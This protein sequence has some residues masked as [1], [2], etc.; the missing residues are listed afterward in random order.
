MWWEI[1]PKN[2]YLLELIKRRPKVQEQNMPFERGLN[3]DQWK[4]FSENYKQWE[5]DYG[6][7]TNLLRIIV[8]CDFWPT[9]EELSY[10]SWQN[11]CFNLSSTCHIK[12][13]FF[14]WTKLLQNLLL[15]KYLL[16]VAA[17][18]KTKSFFIFLFENFSFHFISSFSSRSSWFVNISWHSIIR[19]KTYCKQVFLF[20]HNVSSCCKSKI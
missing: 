4:T 3:F 1:N 19:E 8:A 15:A 11:T 18:L 6:L 14:L 20:L 17:L 7:F 13:K 16:S 9:S 2:K 5:F 12:L 10:L